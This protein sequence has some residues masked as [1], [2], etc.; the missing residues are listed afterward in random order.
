MF[1]ALDVR[2]GAS[3]ACGASVGFEDPRDDK[4]AFVIVKRFEGALRP[5]SLLTADNRLSRRQRQSVAAETPVCWARSRA[6][7]PPGD[8]SFLRIRSRNFSE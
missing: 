6:L 8:R 2:Y 1:V 5:L 3:F 4:P 7:G